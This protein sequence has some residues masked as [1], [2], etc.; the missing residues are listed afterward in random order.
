MGGDGGDGGE[1]QAGDGHE[2]GFVFQGADYE[3]GVVNGLEF[4][5]SSGGNVLDTHD[6]N[7][8]TVAAL[9]AV[10]GLET[11]RSMVADGVAP[12]RSPA[13]RSTSPTRSS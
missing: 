11:A 3:G 12:G 6:P 8:V 4:I 7:E 9:E 1:G 13:S 2:Y 10:A 5:W